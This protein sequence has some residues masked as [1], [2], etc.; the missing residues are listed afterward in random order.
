MG[1]RLGEYTQNNTKCML[2][3][4]GIRLIDRT[5]EILH[6]V[7]V[8]RVVLVVGYKG[9]NVRKYVGYSYKGTPVEYVDNPIYDKTNN[10]YSLFLA[11]DHM[12]SEDTLL[13][14]SDLIY[15]PSVVQK[16]VADPS[17]QHRPCGQ[18]RELDG[19]HRGDHR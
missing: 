7:G 6:N 17:P 4:N 14:E 15:E 11:K 19:R 16:L 9:D 1:K 10:I 2:E 5:L 18:I 3:V 8:S 12:L 13:L